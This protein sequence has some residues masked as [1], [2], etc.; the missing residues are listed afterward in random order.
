MSH[1][2]TATLPQAPEAYSRQAATAVEARL[3]PDPGKWVRRL[4]LLALLSSLAL[5]LAVSRT[6]QSL[7][8][9]PSWQLNA[10]QQHM[11]GESPTF[12]TLVEPDPRDLSQ[13]TA[14]WISWW[15]LGT[16]L[17][18]YPL[19]RIGVSMGAAIRVLAALCLIVGSLGFGYWLK[20]FHLPRW[21]AIALAIGI[22]WIRYANISLFQYAAEALVFA[23]C[24]WLLLGA[25]RLRAR[26]TDRRNL[27]LPFLAG[28]GLLLGFAYWLK[29]SAVFISAG[30]LVHL[31]LT[32]WR[33][34][35]RSITDLAVVSAA[36]AV[37]VATLNVLNHIM[38]AAMN[39]VTERVT[40][41]MDWHLPF[42]FVGLMAMA[43]ADAD[44]LA[45]YALFHPGRSLLPFNYSTLCYL[46]LP[47][48]VILFSLLVRRQTQP[49]LL[50]SRD[51]L[52]TLS[53]LFVGV[54]MVFSARAMEARYVAA[55]GIALIPAALQS[56]FDIAPKL[57]RRVRAL[58]VIAGVLY[59]ALPMA[60]GAF[61]VV[62]KIAR[63]PT[64]YRTGPSGVYNSLFAATDAKTPLAELNAGFNP[65][66]DIWY[67]TE[68][69]TAMDLPGRAILRHADFLS[70]QH[71]QETFRTSKPIRV[72]LLLP[73]WFEENG[74]GRIIRADFMGATDWSSRT[75]PGM[76][77]V[78][79]MAEI[80]PTQSQTLP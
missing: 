5:V 27:T 13:N 46:G 55:I 42:N 3:G 72:H 20:A 4:P 26:W 71:L 18:V 69:F 8:S 41:V 19:L 1:P 70:A 7:F 12:N 56:A 61:S 24:P 80:A 52:V 51:V 23:I 30:V 6:P 45:R 64:N 73:P 63:T 28:F 39:A 17:L 79:W 68:P 11:A 25:L 33:N 40:F 34:R 44:G 48:G 22:P 76:N 32:A 60:Y 43:M 53:A 62:G 74:K 31:G 58:L 78:E 29:Y 59:L 9:D 10:L 57:P 36:C 38:G 49:A 54:M 2:S 65:H 47:G 77:Y 15:P 67:L 75:L 14:E 21:L 66:S 37:A 50:L 35:G 16:N